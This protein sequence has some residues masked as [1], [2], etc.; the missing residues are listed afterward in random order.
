MPTTLKLGTRKSKLAMIQANLVKSS[1]EQTHADV[2]VDIVGMSTAGDRDNTTS[3]YTLGGADKGLWTKE[4]ENALLDGSV[5]VIVHS[6]KDV[7]SQLPAG[8]VLGAFPA[9]EDPTDALV[10]KH[11][12]PYSTLEELPDGSVVGTSSIRR[13]AQL[14]RAFPRLTFKDVRGNLD[15]R[16]AKLDDPNGEFTAIILASAGLKRV[17]EE[18]TQR[19]T[20]RLTDPILYAV[21]QGCLALETREGDAHVEQ[22]ISSINCKQTQLAVTVE[23][24]LL[25]TLEGGCSAPVG[26]ETTVKEENGAHRIHFTAN[27][28]TLDGTTQIRQQL[29]REVASLSDAD[30]LGVDVAHLIQSSGGDKIMADIHDSKTNKIIEKTNIVQN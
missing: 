28:T 29:T 4:L 10:V 19:I 23:R 3:L 21:G 14:R 16:I 5:D 9:R 1:L 24:A 12:L 30:A 8:C 17:S 13:V 20:C 27:L 11:G 7:Q 25:R 26:V 6:L 2:H 15:T 18:Y 22:F